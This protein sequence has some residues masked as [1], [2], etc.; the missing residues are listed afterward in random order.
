MTFRDSLED[1]IDSIINNRVSSR[2]NLLYPLKL[3]ISVF[4]LKRTVLF[5]SRFLDHGTRIISNKDNNLSIFSFD[6]LPLNIL[7][8][9]MPHNLLNYL[10]KFN[11]YRL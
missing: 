6:N 8:N 7:S 2:N 9:I 11:N 5:L 3:S 10:L 4:W 1:G